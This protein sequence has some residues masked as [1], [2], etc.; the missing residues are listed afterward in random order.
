MQIFN[1]VSRWFLTSIR[2][3]VVL[4]TLG[5]FGLVAQSAAPSEALE[6]APMSA[7][8][9]LKVLLGDAA[10]SLIRP[11]AQQVE[12]FAIPPRAETP[13]TVSNLKVVVKHGE[14]V[15]GLLRRHLGDSAFSTKFQRQALVRLNPAVFPRG[16]VQRLPVGTTLWMPTDPIM[17]GLV[18]GGRK[19]SSQAQAASAAD[20][21]ATAGPVHTPS[22]TRGWVR[23]P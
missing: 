22:P 16:M 11:G 19:D 18:P 4:G 8:V 23:F 3:A 7:E 15:N 9:A 17:A 6:D 13:A 5:S 10:P 21:S 20:L 14:T 1:F 2:A 12:I